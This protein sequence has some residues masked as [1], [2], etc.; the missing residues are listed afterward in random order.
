MDLD[1]IKVGIVGC[2]GISRLY[3]G[4]YAGLADVAQVVAVADPVDELAE[5]RRNVMSDA[6]RAE[7]Y[8]LAVLAVDSRTE[9]DRDFHRRKA[10]AAESAA[11]TKI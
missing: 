11:G 6:Y 3:T 8:R 5:T 10:R 2:G 9:K 7:A 4:I 1:T